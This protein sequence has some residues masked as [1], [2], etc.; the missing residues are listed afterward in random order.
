M[1]DRY[2]WDLFTALENKLL[3]MNGQNRQTDVFFQICDS[4]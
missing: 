4:R 3:L 1:S 2:I